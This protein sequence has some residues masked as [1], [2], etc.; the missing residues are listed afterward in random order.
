MSIFNSETVITQHIG[1]ADLRCYFTGFEFWRF[2]YDELSRKIM[3]A[4]IEFALGYHEGILTR[5]TDEQIKRAASL[6]YKI[7]KYDASR[8]DHAKYASEEAF[9][10]AKYLDRGEFWELILHLLLRDFI[11]T[12]PLISKIYFKDARWVTVHGFDAVHIGPSL[13]DS[14]KH[15]LYLWESKLHR[16]WESWVDEL[17]G[18]I[19]KHFAKDF[20]T[21]S[22]GEFVLIHN[23]RNAFINPD[24]L[25]ESHEKEVYKGFLENKDYW[26]ARINEVQE[27]ESLEKLF[28]SITI[29][30][31]C[32]YTSSALFSKHNST[33]TNEFRLE[34]EQ[35]VR[36]L[37]ERFNGRVA[38][39]K[40]KYES[41]WEPISTNL[42]I[43]LMLFPIP[44]KKDLVKILHEKL[45]HRQNI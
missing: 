10:D 37:K 9:F 39:L 18:D 40:K 31:C 38:K 23:K 42:N 44:S 27:G 32:T 1:D 35:E 45:Y 28:D 13:L 43:I 5:Y 14:T 34:Y 33:W 20:L 6:V 8:S 29:P 25:G 26:F 22:A 21:S 11:W 15:S 41:S 7:E 19:E 17:V 16:S 24:D 4:L 36:E 3:N 30:M 2:R 12:I